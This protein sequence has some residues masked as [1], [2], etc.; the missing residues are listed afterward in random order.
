MA[1]T[2][3][4]VREFIRLYEEEFEEKLSVNE[5]RSMAE[6]LIFFL[7]ALASEENGEMRQ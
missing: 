1:L 2:D 6:N 3:D 7:M 4:D 5:A